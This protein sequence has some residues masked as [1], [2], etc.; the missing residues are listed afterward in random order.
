MELDTP[1]HRHSG[2]QYGRFTVMVASVVASP[3]VSAPGRPRR[4]D[5]PERWQ[6]ALRRALD[7]GVRVYQIS[8]TGEYVA[9]STSKPGTAYRCSERD[10]ECEA[11]LFGG[12]PV[13]Q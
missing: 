3:S 9:T 10:C 11:A 13:C 5:T 7:N 12:D 2:Q 4:H 6:S 1:P 8:G